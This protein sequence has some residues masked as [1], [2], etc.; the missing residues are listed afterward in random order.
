MHLAAYGLTPAFC[1]LRSRTV[2][3][4]AT[5][6]PLVCRKAQRVPNLASGGLLSRISPV[7]ETVK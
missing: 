5:F 3:F 2:D 7:S 4:F 6:D 1:Q